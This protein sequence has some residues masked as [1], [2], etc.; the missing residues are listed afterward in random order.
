MGV[1]GGEKRKGRGEKRG[2]EEYVCQ[3]RKIREAAHLDFWE[4]FARRL[5]Y[6]S[7]SPLE[8]CNIFQRI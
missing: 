7:L 3:P 8:E 2:K 5:M 4:V 6:V 1:D